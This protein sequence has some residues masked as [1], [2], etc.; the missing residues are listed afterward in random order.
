MSIDLS[1]Y[2]IFQF[3]GYILSSI[4]INKLNINLIPFVAILLAWMIRVLSKAIYKSSLFIYYNRKS[5][6]YHF[7]IPVLCT[8]LSIGIVIWYVFK[9]V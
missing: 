6:N 3:I 8:I 7:A 2:A 1:N 5:V 9:G 4:G